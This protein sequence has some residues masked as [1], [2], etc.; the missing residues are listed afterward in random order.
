M[1]LD[2]LLANSQA[3]TASRILISGM[4][5]LKDVE[6][7]FAKLRSKADSV[8]A[9]RKSPFAST[10]FDGDMDLWGRFSTELERVV[11]EVLDHVAQLGVI[12]HYRGQ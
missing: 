4:Q 1:A 12:R 8:I 11:D 2:D 6:D 9:D 10:G 3:N 5:T 7:A